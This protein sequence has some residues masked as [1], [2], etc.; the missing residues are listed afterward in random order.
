MIVMTLTR[1]E[2]AR[3]ASN[4]GVKKGKNGLVS[5]LPA[6]ISPA[7]IASDGACAI[8]RRKERTPTKLTRSRRGAARKETSD[9][10]EKLLYKEC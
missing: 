6:A 4:E 1:T 3:A 7:G 9:G 8:E 10:R 2:P 5:I